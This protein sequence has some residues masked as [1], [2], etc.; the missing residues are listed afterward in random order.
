MQTALP[1]GV[2]QKH[3]ITPHTENV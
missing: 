1:N 2:V 3:S